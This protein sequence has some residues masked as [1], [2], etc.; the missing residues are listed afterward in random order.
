M[1]VLLSSVTDPELRHELALATRAVGCGAADGDVLRATAARVPDD[2]ADAW[3]LEWLAT[4][5]GAWADANAAADAGRPVA[6]RRS[7]L[8]AATYYAI[9]LAAIG[10]SAEAD[11]CLAVGRR[12]RCCWERAVAC[13]DPPGVPLVVPHAGTTLPAWFFPA[14]SAE[15]GERRAT[16]IV[17]PGGDGPASQAW[18]LGGA[19]ASERGCHWIAFDGPG[20]R[21]ALVEQRLILRPDG[22]VLTAVVDLLL[23]RDDVDPARVAVIGVGPAG[24]WVPR[25]L[26]VEHRLA[27]AV[28]DPGVVELSARWLA[29]LPLPLRE[30]LRDGDR[31]GFARE[32]HLAELFAPELGDRLRRSGAPYGVEGGSAAAL[33]DALGGFRLGDELRRITT[34]MLVTE[35]DDEPFWPGQSRRLVD[36]LTGPRRLLGVSPETRDERIFAWLDARLG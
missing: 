8:H 15:P 27:A 34:P 20:P 25:A 19:A 16:V 30:R 12:Q 13:F 32:L 35:S 26:A 36:R 17:S 29:L 9:A 33:Y 1:V 6:A 3:V 31:D 24:Y 22:E 4:A 10:R 18:V 2:D 7:Y 14:P 28:A 21:T 11:R 23:A 5:G